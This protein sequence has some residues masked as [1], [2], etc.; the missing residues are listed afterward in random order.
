LFILKVDE[1]D[2]D[3]EAKIVKKTANL[4]GGGNE[5]I[6]ITDAVNGEMKVY[7]VPAD[8]TG[9]DSGT[10]YWGIRI[11]TSDGK[12]FASNVACEFSIDTAIATDSI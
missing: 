1:S 3:S 4:A 2:P 5:Q 11:K 9:L 10:Y 6:E 7:I 12:Q 8:T